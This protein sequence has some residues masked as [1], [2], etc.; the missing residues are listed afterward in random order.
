MPICYIISLSYHATL[1]QMACKKV[2]DLSKEKE[3]YQFEVACVSYLNLKQN[4]AFKEDV[5]KCLS[6]QFYVKAS[7]QMSVTHW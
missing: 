2:N 7:L 1:C 5:D 4:K 6:Y 3:E